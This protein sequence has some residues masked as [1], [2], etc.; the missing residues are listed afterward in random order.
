MKKRAIVAIASKILKAIYHIIKHKAEFI[1]LGETYITERRKN[2]KLKFLN[3]QAKKF[4]Y[5]LIKHN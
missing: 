2:A 5:T 3:K 4:G 1:D